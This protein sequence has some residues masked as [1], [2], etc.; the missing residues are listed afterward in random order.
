MVRRTA[1]SGRDEK[2]EA[3][4]KKTCFMSL[5]MPSVKFF[6][7]VR[8]KKKSRTKTKKISRVNSGF[9]ARESEQLR[10]RNCCGWF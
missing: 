4:R 7:L 6:V 3:V 8:E 10:F 2:C 1:D 9:A 5:K